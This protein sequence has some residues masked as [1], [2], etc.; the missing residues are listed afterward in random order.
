MLSC[1]PAIE[2]TDNEEDV[3]GEHVVF[4]R[5]DLKV[6]ATSLRHLLRHTPS[7]MC[8]S[9]CQMAKAQTVRR[10]RG[11]ADGK[12]SAFFGDCIT[13]D[14]FV[15]DRHSEDV[16]LDEMLNGLVMSDVAIGFLD[17]EPSRERDVDITAAKLGFFVGGSTVTRF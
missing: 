12:H 4:P 8:C 3:E 2:E 17:C 6:D 9:I 7:N 11:P 15:V 13:A 5:R 1:A 10:V 14:Y 16:A